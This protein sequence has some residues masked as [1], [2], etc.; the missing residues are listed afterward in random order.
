M[1]I[2]AVALN[3]SD[4]L[5]IAGKYQIKPQIPFSPGGEFSGIAVEI[6]AGPRAHVR[7]GETFALGGSGGAG[8]SAVEIGK[9]M[10]AHLIACASSESKLDFVRSHGADASINYMKQNLKTELR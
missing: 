7:N 3:F 1:A 10:G 5:L 2:K 8:M 4:T 6:D 9:V